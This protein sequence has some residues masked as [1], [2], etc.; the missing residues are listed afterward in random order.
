VHRRQDYHSNAIK[1]VENGD[2]FTP[3]GPLPQDLVSHYDVQPLYDK[4]AT[5]AGQTIGIVTLADFNE[6]DAYDF[7][8]QM[9]INVKPS[10]ITKVNVDGGSDWNSYDETSL[11]V[12]QSGALAPKQIFAY[13]LL[14]T[15][16]P[17]LSTASRRL[18][19]RIRRNR[20]PSAG[21]KVRRPSLIS[22]SSS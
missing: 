7:L 20:F 14:P 13:T 9:G 6:Q 11:E 8:N 17:D 12:E 4:G 19:T 16:T 21:E 1:R 22:S 18:S 10:R 5:G 3:T 2:A 15:A